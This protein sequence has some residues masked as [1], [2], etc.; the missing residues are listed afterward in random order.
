[1]GIV[2]TFRVGCGCG[3]GMLRYDEKNWG[4]QKTAV[5]AGVVF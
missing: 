2:G 3:C 5:K 1:M 4:S